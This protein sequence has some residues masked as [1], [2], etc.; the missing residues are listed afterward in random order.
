MW[1]G[2]ATVQGCKDFPND[3]TRAAP[4]R[5]A[6]PDRETL[7]N[8]EAHFAIHPLRMEI[9]LGLALPIFLPVAVRRG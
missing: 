2:C 5:S 6:S 1:A 7:D 4:A 9:V 3:R 8:P